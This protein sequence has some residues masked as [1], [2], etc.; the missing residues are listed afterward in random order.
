MNRAEKTITVAAKLYEARN[1]IK[2]TMRPGKYAELMATYGRALKKLAATSEQS[3]LKVAQERAKFA[4]ASG[5]PRFASIILAAAVELIE[6]EE[7][8]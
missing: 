4:L 1:A 7:G 3:I 2:G 8:K 5:E 6:A